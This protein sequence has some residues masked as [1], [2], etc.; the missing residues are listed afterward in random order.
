[1]REKIKEPKVV[2]CF[3]GTMYSLFLVV[4][5]AQKFS[6]DFY[7]ACIM[8]EEVVILLKEHAVLLDSCVAQA[9][10]KSKVCCFILFY[11]LFFLQMAS[12]WV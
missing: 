2:Q 8:K 5:K 12:S 9:M 7:V 1:M 10:S 6:G 11:F 4:K 3:T